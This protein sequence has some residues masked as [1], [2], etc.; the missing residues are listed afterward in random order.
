MS[1]PGLTDQ[2]REALACRCH[3]A[4]CPLHNDASTGRVEWEPDALFAAVEEIVAARGVDLV[5]PAP[6][7]ERR[8][9]WPTFGVPRSPAPTEDRGVGSDVIERV[10]AVIDPMG[11]PTD[12]THLHPQAASL[13]VQI[14]AALAPSTP[15]DQR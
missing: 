4:L 9:P 14:R 7:V 1:G 10:R 12:P 6:M 2:E 11:D 8:R 5:S 13:I 15:E 3:E